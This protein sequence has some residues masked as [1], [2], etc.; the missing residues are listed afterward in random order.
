MLFI[1]IVICS[2][3]SLRALDNYVDFH[4][5]GNHNCTS[6]RILFADNIICVQKH[7]SDGNHHTF[8]LCICN[9]SATKKLSEM[10]CVYLCNYTRLYLKM[11]MLYDNAI[12]RRSVQHPNSVLTR[13]NLFTPLSTFTL[14]NYIA[15][16]PVCRSSS[17]DLGLSHTVGFSICALPTESI[18]A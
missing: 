8:Y 14:Y 9:V 4:L 12:S 3:G 10:V 13:T 5:K 18:R 2:I 16:V 6:E 7:A 1:S 15:C 17:P 11:I